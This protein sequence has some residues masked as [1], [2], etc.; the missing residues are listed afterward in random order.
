L[1]SRA[2]RLVPFPGSEKTMWAE[3]NTVEVPIE[4]L[5]VSTYTIPSDFP[6]ADGTL[7]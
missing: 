1:L 7:A 6:E 5:A 3:I 4:Q 2:D